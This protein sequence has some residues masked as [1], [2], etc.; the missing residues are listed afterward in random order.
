M[1]QQI[2]LLMVIMFLEQYLG[3]QVGPVS[4]SIYSSHTHVLSL[5]SPLQGGASQETPQTYS[6]PIPIPIPQ[7]NE[8]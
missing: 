4:T 5:H 1:F 7:S 8:S 2:H 3:N 6:L